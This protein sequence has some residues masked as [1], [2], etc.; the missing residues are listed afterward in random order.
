MKFVPK[1]VPEGINT[2]KVS[3]LREFIV[4]SFG[5]ILLLTI[6]VIL[7]SLLT[8]QLVRYIPVKTEYKLFSFTHAI[9]RPSQDP[10]SAQ[11]R[12]EQYLSKL[13]DRLQKGRQGDKQP[14]TVAVMDDPMP[15]AF[16]L[17]GGHIVVT[18]SLFRHIQS[19]NGL[20]MVLGHEMGHQ[21]ARHPLRSMGRGVVV[22]L[23]IAVFTGTDGS[24]MIKS[25]VDSTVELG[26]LKFDRD[27]ERAADDTAVSL[28]QRVYGHAGGA[29]EFFQSIQK[30]E[31]KTGKNP[32]PGFM[33]THPTTQERINH[34]QAIVDRTGK[35]KLVELPDFVKNY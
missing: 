11:S 21:Y 32:L 15:N 4:L 19:E 28:L 34:L 23:A 8:D 6:T 29:D 24:E 12:V 18:S 20:A 27:Q 14:F 25:M 7:L 1:P 30:L 35:A 33:K 13:I 9:A 2:T 16:A 31:V 22:L 17:P 5:L 26:L 10:G 3:H